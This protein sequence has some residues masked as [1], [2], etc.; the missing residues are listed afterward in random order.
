[1]KKSKRIIVFV[2]SILSVL[3]LLVGCKNNSNNEDVKNNN[4]LTQ[5]DNEY[6]QNSSDEELP[7]EQDEIINSIQY[8]SLTELLPEYS[9]ENAI[10]DNCFVIT[11]DDEVYNDNLLQGFENSIS[12]SVPTNLR[13][14]MQAIDEKLSIIDINYSGD[15]IKV[16][17]DDTR[18]EGAIQENIYYVSDGYTFGEETVLLE[19]GTS[20]KIY[21]LVNK[22]LEEKIELFG[23]VIVENESL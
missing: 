3:S 20:V 18:F 12:T 2:I 21:Q 7:L 22:N 16:V 23:Y 5:N 8:T 14:V 10:E 9:I 1:M 19:D 6:L 17:Q 11:K 15:E 4:Q 13:V